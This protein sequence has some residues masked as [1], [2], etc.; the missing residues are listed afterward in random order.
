MSRMMGCA[1]E[2]KVEDESMLLRICDA[3]GSWPG[4]ADI[5]CSQGGKFKPDAALCRKPLELL[6]RKSRPDS[7]VALQLQ[8]VLKASYVL[9][10][11][12]SCILLQAGRCDSLTHFNN[13][14]T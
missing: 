14:M 3:A 13:Q 11:Y 4:V 6:M 9:K 5:L 1:V 2:Q 8:Q 12:L 7:V 10:T